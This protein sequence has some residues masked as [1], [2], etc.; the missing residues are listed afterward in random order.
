MAVQGFTRLVRLPGS[1]KAQHFI[2]FGVLSVLIFA[3]A[4]ATS[5]P[6]MPRR[7][8]EALQPLLAASRSF[9]W[10]DVG[11]NC[12]GAAVFLLAAWAVDRWAIQPRASRF[13]GDSARYW[14]VGPANSSAGASDDE[15][16]DVELDEIVVAAA[17]AA[18][19]R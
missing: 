16:F 9:Q 14:A 18:R 5:S 2:E 8:V 4:A 15:D 12:S 6:L 13:Y 7:R 3:S 17:S 10:G 19:R 1:D 11:A